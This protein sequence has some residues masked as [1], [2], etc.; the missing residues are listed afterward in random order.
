[1]IK[2]V[3]T[4]V[5]KEESLF[6]GKKS[7]CP[8]CGEKVIEIELENTDED[9]S[10]KGKCRYCQQIKKLYTYETM[11]RNAFYT[12]Y[13]I[14]N[15]CYECREQVEKNHKIKEIMDKI[16][17]AK[18]IRVELDNMHYLGNIFLKKKNKLYKIYAT[19]WDDRYLE[20]EEMGEEEE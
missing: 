2:M 15:I 11:G 3:K 8:A 6:E 17:G 10:F 18:V 14:H 16:A 9:F 13:F 5:K 19:G 20:I 4:I 1:M 12:K 7:V